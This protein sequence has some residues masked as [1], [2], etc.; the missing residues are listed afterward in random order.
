MRCWLNWF[1]V[2]FVVFLCRRFLVPV[3]LSL[4]LVAALV[5]C[6]LSFGVLVAVCSSNRYPS[7]YQLPI[8]CHG[9]CTRTRFSSSSCKSYHAPQLLGGT[10]SLFRAINWIWRRTSNHTSSR[11][12]VSSKSPHFCPIANTPPSTYI[13]LPRRNSITTHCEPGTT[14]TSHH[15]IFVSR[16]TLHSLSPLPSTWGL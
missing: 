11:I 13:G 10:T 14:S 7:S 6:C 15:C 9:S 4:F 2:V 12:T 1:F 8:L 3:P 5:R 16:L